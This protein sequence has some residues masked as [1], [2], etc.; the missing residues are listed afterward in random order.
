MTNVRSL[1]FAHTPKYVLLLL[2]MLVSAC[3]NNDSGRLE[4][5][6]ISVIGTNDV[7]GALAMAKERGGLATLS[8]YIDA[9]RAAREQDGGAVVL[10]DARDMWQGTV[11]SKLTQGAAG[12]QAHHAMR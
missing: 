2:A 11:A 4:P 8:G 5:I 1:L 10:I 7:H 6:R 3:T 12:V 9:V